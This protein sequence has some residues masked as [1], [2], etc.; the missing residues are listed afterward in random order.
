MPICTIKAQNGQAVLPFRF[1]W[2]DGLKIPQYD[3]SG[4]EMV[5]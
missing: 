3:A 2:S 4:K 1:I 5:T